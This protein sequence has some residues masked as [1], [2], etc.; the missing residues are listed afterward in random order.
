MV[1][2][3]RHL[4][5]PTMLVGL[6]LA[7][8]GPAGAAADTG[9]WGTYAPPGPGYLL[10]K[11]D[12]TLY[13]SDLNDA[14]IY[15]VSPAGVVTVFAG[16]GPGGFANGYTGDGGPAI[17]AEFGGVVGL[18]WAH[19]GSMLAIDHLNDAVRRIDAAGI[20]TTVAGSGGLSTWSHGAWYPHVK[21]TGD[22]GPATSAQLDA[23]WGLEVDAAG[24]MY[25]SDRDHD[26]IRR[27]D[28]NGIITTV[29]GTGQRGFSGDGGLATDAKLSRPMDVAFTPGGGFYIA[30]ENNARVRY[31][32]S[33]GHISTFAGNGTLGCGGDF[34]PA[35]QA[36]L[37]NVG[38][39]LLKPDGSLI[40]GDGECQRVR[41]IGT[42]GI[43]RPLLGNG[44]E[45]CGEYE[46]AVAININIF[47]AAGLAWDNHGQ[48]LVSDP[49]CGFIIRIDNRGRVHIVADFHGLGGF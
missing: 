45:G 36:S 11:P 16:S 24:N 14:R 49:G 25:I 23:P 47:G 19:D 48:L 43:I 22:G 6:L 40:V 32:D 30:D 4:L 2:S 12:G 33:T 34:G 38:Y 7:L 35:T 8:A 27:V 41:V 1:T 31:V 20:V 3:G 42:D 5:F 37:Q 46:G 21:G 39:L 18:A 26:A 17:D 13:T 9:T 44:P 15:Q 29:A 28:T 10:V